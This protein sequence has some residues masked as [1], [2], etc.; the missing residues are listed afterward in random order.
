MWVW[1]DK[2]IT[3]EISEGPFQDKKHQR[4]S[5][6]ILLWPLH[7]HAGVHIHT[8]TYT[9]HASTCIYHTPTL[10]SHSQVHFLKVTIPTK[11][12]WIKDNNT[13]MISNYGKV[14]HSPTKHVTMLKYFNLDS[15]KNSINYGE[16]DLKY[17]FIPQI[18]NNK[19]R[20]EFIFSCSE[21]STVDGLK[22]SGQDKLFKLFIL[23]LICS[24]YM[25]VKWPYILTENTI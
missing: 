16:Q 15:E 18:I 9:H 8:L 11:V 13:H 21:L 5:P 24:F 10:H 3:T 22:P 14:F 4:K 1:Q 6:S 17:R 7:V 12:A 25:S 23:L 20:S 19:C 2:E